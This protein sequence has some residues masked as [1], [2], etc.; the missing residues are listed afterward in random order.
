MMVVP[1]LMTSC[2][3]AEAKDRAGDRPDDYDR[4]CEQKSRQAS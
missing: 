1:V 3:V 4:V 2:H